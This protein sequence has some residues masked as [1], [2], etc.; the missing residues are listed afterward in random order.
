MKT[1]NE[2]QSDLKLTV[3]MLSVKAEKK[4]PYYDEIRHCRRSNLNLQN[5]NFMVSWRSNLI[6]ISDFEAK[7][8]S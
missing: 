2:R 1:L 5:A 8:S 7:V 4:I 6:P 3:L